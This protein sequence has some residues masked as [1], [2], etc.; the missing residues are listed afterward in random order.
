MRSQGS[1]PS[2]PKS[3]P[4][5]PTEEIRE[6]M[7]QGKATHQCF[8]AGLG[9]ILAKQVD[10]SL[11]CRFFVDTELVEAGPKG[12]QVVDY[13]F[14]EEFIVSSRGGGRIGGHGRQGVD[15]EKQPG[16]HSLIDRGDNGDR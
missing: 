10:R 3:V 16:S 14:R 2:E 11:Q 12:V 4:F 1:G 8:K 6:E 7:R 15:R 13:V 9:L 5:R